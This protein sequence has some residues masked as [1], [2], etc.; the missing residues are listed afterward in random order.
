M[1][2]LI[3]RALAGLTVLVIGTGVSLAQGAKEGEQKLKHLDKSSPIL[4]KQGAQKP[5]PALRPGPAVTD[6]GVPA[7]KLNKKSTQ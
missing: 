1:Q 5:T 7:D 4:M 2:K 3:I 6:E